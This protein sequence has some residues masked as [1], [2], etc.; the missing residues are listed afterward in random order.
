MA[1]A[2]AAPGKLQDGTGHSVSLSDLVA[3]GPVYLLFIHQ[4]CPHSWVATPYFDQLSKAYGAKTPVV[5]IINADQKGYLAWQDRFHVPYRVL[6]DPSKT[7]MKTLHA[8]SSPWVLKIGTGG[9]ILRSW[10][11]LSVGILRSI[12]SDMALT[13]KL[14]AI[15]LKTDG[16]PTVR[17]YGCLFD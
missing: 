1:A 9:N 12:N 8:P 13:S 4:T 15:K 5:G 10:G 7:W 6:Q 14:P 16:A 3:H 11:G 17:Q 2:L